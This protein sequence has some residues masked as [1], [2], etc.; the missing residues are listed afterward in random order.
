MTAANAGMSA[1][2]NEK[3]SELLMQWST[4]PI[5]ANDNSDLDY[6]SNGPADHVIFVIH[7]SVFSSLFPNHCNSYVFTYIFD[8]QGIGQQTEKYGMFKQH[9]KLI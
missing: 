6:T 3:T 8:T 5:T 9:S 2:D 1:A 4:P 7:A